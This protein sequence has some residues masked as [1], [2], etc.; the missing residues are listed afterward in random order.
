MSSRVIVPKASRKAVRV[1]L[2]AAQCWHEVGKMS[3]G[4]TMTVAYGLLGIYIAI[5]TEAC[6]VGEYR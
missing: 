1:L 4:D 5:T 2:E 3:I 6:N